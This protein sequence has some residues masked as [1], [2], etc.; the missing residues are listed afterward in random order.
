MSKGGIISAAENVSGKYKHYFESPLRGTLMMKDG[1]FYN[2]HANIRAESQNIIIFE[3]PLRLNEEDI[4]F[5][6]WR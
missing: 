2:V 6:Y 5:T 4:V 3:G 1:T